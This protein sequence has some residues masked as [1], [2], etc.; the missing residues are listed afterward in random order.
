MEINFNP[1]ISLMYV[2]LQWSSAK[3]LGTTY[4]VSGLETFITTPVAITVD[5]VTIIC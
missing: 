5:K 4:K 1:N 2:D 3:F